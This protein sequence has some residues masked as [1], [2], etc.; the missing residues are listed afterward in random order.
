MTGKPIM[1]VG[2]RVGEEYLTFKRW[3]D[4]FISSLVTMPVE[5]R[6]KNTQEMI[7]YFGQ[8]A[9]TRRAHGAEDLITALVESEIEGESLE[10]WEILGFC[11]LLLIAGNETTTNSR[12]LTAVRLPPYGK[13][14]VPSCSASITCRWC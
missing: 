13:Q 8:M 1:I 3:S 7:V 11:I 4:C 6:M 12:C 14:E 2:L 5:E 10:D 9:A